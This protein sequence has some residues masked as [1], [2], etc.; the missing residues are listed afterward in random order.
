MP[1]L[2]LAEQRINPII[3]ENAEILQGVEVNLSTLKI[4]K[5]NLTKT[6]IVKK[7]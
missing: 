6:L 7:G 5:K 3:A 2:L 1:E 4:A